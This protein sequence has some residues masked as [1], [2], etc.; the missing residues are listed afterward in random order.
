MSGK[1]RDVVAEAAYAIAGHGFTEEEAGNVSEGTPWQ[2][3]VVIS[4]VLL[5]NVAEEG[6]AYRLGRW[7][8]HNHMREDQTIYVW[9]SEDTQGFVDVEMWAQN[10]DAVLSEYTP[11]IAK[12]YGND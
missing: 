3:V 5:M 12:E 2:A 8:I 4:P 9:L 7:L 6:L 11:H 10:L 1:F